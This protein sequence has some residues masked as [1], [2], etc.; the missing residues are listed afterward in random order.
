MLNR[1]PDL[2]EVVRVNSGAIVYIA[3]L[4]QRKVLD[5]ADRQGVRW[6]AVG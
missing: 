5:G 2:A 1:R 6:A 3:N 4:Y